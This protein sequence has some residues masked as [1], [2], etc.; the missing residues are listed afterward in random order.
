MMKKTRQEIYAERLHQSKI[1]RE[2][3]MKDALKQFH[4]D[5]LDKPRKTRIRFKL[6]KKSHV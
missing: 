1:S 2:L 3:V 5:S 6:T 4:G